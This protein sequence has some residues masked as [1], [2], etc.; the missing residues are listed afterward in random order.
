MT[1]AFLLGLALGLFLGFAAYAL[2]NG[3]TW[4]AWFYGSLGFAVVNAACRLTGK[5]DNEAP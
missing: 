3:S 2:S 4:L 5:P 1:R